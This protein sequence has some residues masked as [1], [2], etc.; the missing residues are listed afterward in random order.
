MKIDAP[1][2]PYD[3]PTMN[4]QDILYQEEPE[5]DMCTINDSFFANE[6]IDR[7]R[8][9]RMSLKNCKFNNTNF[10]HIDIT[11]VV[12]ENCD[13]SNAIL[14]SSSIHRVTFKNC[15]LLGVDFTESRFGNV[16]F[17]NS[18]L[19]LTGFGNSKLEKVVF[20][21]ASLVNSDFYD[22]KFK[23]IEFNLCNINSANFEQTPLKG[24]DISNSTFEALTVSLEDLKGCK[25]NSNQAI[26]F[27]ALLGLII[28]E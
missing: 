13:F 25:V 28:M 15:K 19:N 11:D 10:S 21:E 27:A 4:F 22:C 18:I 23:N 8:L 7:A 26:Q 16:L 17:D 9:S 6:A 5:L 3:L 12:F 24:I 2:I 14:R 20:Q 1:K